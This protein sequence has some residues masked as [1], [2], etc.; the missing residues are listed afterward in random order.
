[1]NNAVKLSS[2]DNL[3]N[4]ENNYGFTES[5]ISKDGEKNK[6]FFLG[7]K[8]DWTKLLDK[9]IINEINKEFSVEMKELGY[10]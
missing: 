2:F 1:M 8:N 5:S 3:K 9:E 10:L 4:M 7:P 6:F